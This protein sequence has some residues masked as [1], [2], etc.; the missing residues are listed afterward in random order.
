M[1]RRTTAHF[2][3]ILVDKKIEPKRICFE[4]IWQQKTVNIYLHSNIFGV[5]IILFFLLLAKAKNY[6]NIHSTYT[7]IAA[8]KKCRDEVKIQKVGVLLIRI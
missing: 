4:T 7:D 5:H 1:T 8:I 3:C 6:E 2:S